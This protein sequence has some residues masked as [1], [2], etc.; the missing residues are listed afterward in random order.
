VNKPNFSRQY[1]HDLPNDHAPKKEK[2]AKLPQPVL[3]P[4]FMVG[5]IQSSDYGLERLLIALNQAT[6]GNVTDHLTKWDFVFLRNYDQSKPT[7]DIYAIPRTNDR[8]HCWSPY[9]VY[10]LSERQLAEHRET[11]IKA[12]PVIATFVE[13]WLD[14]RSWQK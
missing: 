5:Q 3:L 6:F 8:K 4:T 11:F 10:D 1:Y 2:E 7:V 9:G 13:G 12:Q 14:G